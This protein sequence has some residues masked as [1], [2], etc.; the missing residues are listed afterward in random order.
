MISD[1]SPQDLLLELSALSFFV[2]YIFFSFCDGFNL[3]I[4]RK[5]FWGFCFLAVCYWSYKVQGHFNLKIIILC[6]SLLAFILGRIQQQG[7]LKGKR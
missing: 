1:M 5:I 7:N 3:R 4:E 2:F 6:S